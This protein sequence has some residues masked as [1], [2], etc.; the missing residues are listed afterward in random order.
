LRR[1]LVT[2]GS[3]LLGRRV[4]R[5]LSGKCHLFCAGRSRP[6]DFSAAE[7]VEL[8]LEMP[9]FAD[10]LPS[11]ADAVIHLAQADG[12]ANFPADARSIFAVNVAAFAHLLE[13]ARSAGASHVVHASSGGVYGTGRDAFKETDPI[14]I[15]GRLAFYN[16]TKHAAETLANAYQDQFTVIALR[17]F[18]IYGA[19]QTKRMLIPRL[20]QNVREGT[21]LKLAGA[22][23]IRLNPIY[24]DDA[25]L[26]TVAALDVPDSGIINVAGPQVVSIR[27]IGDTI[28]RRLGTSA[29]Y[30]LAGE[31]SGDDVVAD[32]A[33][34]RAILGAPHSSFEA[35]IIAMLPSPAQ[36]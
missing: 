2:G 14:R 10:R 29:R 9:G 25:A 24:V 7:F 28:A 13:W 32:T 6:P 20:I 18:F 26:A 30:E 22:T 33:R 23:G 3:G 4:V 15:S 11:R 16:S 17:Y 5:L 27:D 34:M 8:D 31:R 21:P 12:Y 19:G 35:G 1:I 36:G